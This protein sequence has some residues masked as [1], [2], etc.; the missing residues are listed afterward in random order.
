M[1]IV[2]EDGKVVGIYNNELE[3]KEAAGIQARLAGAIVEES[4]LDADLD[5]DGVIEKA[6]LKQWLQKDEE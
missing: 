6:E 2:E 4:I 1:W 3:A 5:G